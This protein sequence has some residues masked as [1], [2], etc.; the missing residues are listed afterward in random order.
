MNDEC[1]ERAPQRL[2]LLSEL[3]NCPEIAPLLGSRASA[4]W[5]ARTRRR[6]YVEGNALVLIRG[7]WHC[8]PARFRAVLLDVAR[9][10]A[11]ASCTRTEAAH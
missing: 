10:R 2:V 7:R 3:H 5:E 6:A 8:D 1:I 4:E 9:Q 11:L